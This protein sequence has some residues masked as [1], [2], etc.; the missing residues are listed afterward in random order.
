MDKGSNSLVQAQIVAKPHHYLPGVTKNSLGKT[1][2][3]N[4]FSHKAKN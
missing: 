2:K 4:S 1:A 3:S